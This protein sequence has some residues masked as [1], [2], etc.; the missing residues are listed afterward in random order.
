MNGNKKQMNMGSEGIFTAISVGFFFVLIG[1]L[2]VTT[3]NLFDNFLDF[4]KSFRLIDVP[5]SNIVLP[6][7]VSPENH[8]KLYQ[9]AELLSFVLVAFQIVMLLLRFFARS[10]WGKRAETVGNLVFWLGAGFLIQSFLIKPPTQWFIFWSLLI[11]IIGISMIARAMVIAG[12][13]LFS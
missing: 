13:R 5:N 12:S 6:G 10:S 3:P 11:I 2:L 9:A 8:I 1:I 4:V 7:P